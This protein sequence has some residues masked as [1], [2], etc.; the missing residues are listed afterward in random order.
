MPLALNEYNELLDAI[1]RDDAEKVREMLIGKVD[2][3][4][5]PNPHPVT[6]ASR[7]G[8]L[9][10]FKV[11]LAAGVDVNKTYSG[12]PPL[13][14]AAWSG[15]NPLVQFL[16]A[17]GANIHAVT[18]PERN[19]ALMMAALDGREKTVEILLTAG[20]LPNARNSK[21]FTA[22]MFAAKSG[23]YK[24][25]R[26]L[27]DNKAD[28]YAKNQ[29][30]QTAFDLAVKYRNVSVAELLNPDVKEAMLGCEGKKYRITSATGRWKNFKEPIAADIS[31]LPWCFTFRKFY[32]EF[33]LDRHGIMPHMIITVFDNSIGICDLGAPEALWTELKK[34]T[35]FWMKKYDPDLTMTGASKG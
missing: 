2:L 31:D 17:S 4:D 22:L 27:I 35:E 18:H 21:G 30:G 9:E 26:R 29:E 13:V 25:A 10:T 33:W 23:Y 24:I 5:F 15:R 11:M 1:K 32:Y 12:E 3:N 8:H 14:T 34:L 6:V 16:L 28:I 19:T 7:Y 20:A